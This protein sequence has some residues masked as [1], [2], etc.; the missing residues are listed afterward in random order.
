MRCACTAYRPMFMC[1]DVG[2]DTK[3]TLLPLGPTAQQLGVPAT[4]LRQEAER[5][6][7]P[8][9]KAGKRLLFDLETVARLLSERARGEGAAHAK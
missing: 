3:P 1:H 2:V 9:L 6:S 4:W 5:G 7:I 8:H